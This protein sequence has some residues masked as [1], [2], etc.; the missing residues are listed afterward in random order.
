MSRPAG[1]LAVTRCI[2]NDPVGNV[3]EGYF[4]A[5]GRCVM[6]RDYT[7]R[8]TP[9]LPVTPTL[10]RPA[11]KLRAG[12]PD[13][14]ETRWNW[15]SDSLCTLEISPGGQQVQYIYES[16]FDKS[17][18]ARKRADCRVVREL[19]AGG[20][21]LNGDG[22]ADVTER[23]WRYEYDPRFGSDPAASRLRSGVIAEVG[24]LDDPRLHD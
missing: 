14:Y 8:A 12:D 18:Q 17:A 9:G 1:S 24:V 23:V 10:N 15:N 2:V 20:V 19:A 3:T 21:D 7:G 6:E 13:Y 4:D 11:G 22:T 5:R 16:D